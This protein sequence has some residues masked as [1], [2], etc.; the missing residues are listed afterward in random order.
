MMKTHYWTVSSDAPDKEIIRRA[1]DLINSGELV[2]FPT[3]TVYGLGAGAYFPAAVRK[4]FEVKGREAQR[5]LLVHVSNHDQVRPLVADIPD[6]ARIL[7]ERFWPGPLAIILPADPRVPD[8]VRGGF[9]SVGLRMPAHPVALAF[10]EQAGPIA[11]PSA[12]LTGRPSPVTAEHVKTD[13]D[14]K[15]AA[16]LDAGPTG[17]GL[18]STIIDL[19]T[20]RPRLIRRGGLPPEEVEEVLEVTLIDT[21][22]PAQTGYQTRLNIHLCTDQ[23]E[24]RKASLGRNGTEK[25][26]LVVYQNEIQ[27]VMGGKPPEYILDLR[28]PSTD[29]FSI[30]RDAEERGFQRLVFAPLPG[31][32]TG[33]SAGLADRIRRAALSDD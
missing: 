25:I 14:G 24:L 30:I 1:A 28:G 32:L 15:I 5:P 29:L 7:M 23:S 11:A 12:N 3:E 22:P 19:S 9:S 6:S 26:A 21:L 13:L 31:D 4:I 2:A 20:P 16:V 33:M 18:E 10:I 8:E 17:I 27:G